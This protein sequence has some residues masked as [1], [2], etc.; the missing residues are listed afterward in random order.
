ML[1]NKI[2]WFSSLW[3]I[4]TLMRYCAVIM[5]LNYWLVLI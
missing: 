4:L 2:D 3:E 5:L 1:D